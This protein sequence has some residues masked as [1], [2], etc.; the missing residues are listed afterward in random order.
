MCYKEE[1]LITMA[2]GDHKSKKELYEKLGDGACFLK[3]Y[4]KAIEYYQKMLQEAKQNGEVGKDLS[5]CYVSLAQTYSDNKQYGLA[6]DYFQKELALW[7]NDLKESIRTFFNIIDIMELAEKSVIEI[8]KLYLKIRKQCQQ[9]GEKQ[10]EGSILKKYGDFL[11]KHEELQE[12]LEVERELVRIG[13]APTD[14]DSEGSEEN[15][16]PNIGDDIDTDDI[17]GILYFLVF[18]SVFKISKFSVT[19]LNFLFSH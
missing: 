13:F 1:S 18:F 8:K 15:N 4:T 9:A 16:T 12:A 19:F 14:Q 17:T 3:N 11:R 6:L 10:L 7:K 2:D 5:P